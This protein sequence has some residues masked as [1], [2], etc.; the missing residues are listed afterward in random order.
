M[1][2]DTY[3]C[4]SRRVGRDKRRARSI[5]GSAIAAK[6]PDEFRHLSANP[7]GFSP[8]P[9]AIAVRPEAATSSYRS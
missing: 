7:D 6:C 3:G 4:A 5:N 9:S 8:Y 1:E 2:F